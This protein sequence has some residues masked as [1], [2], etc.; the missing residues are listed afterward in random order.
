MIEYSLTRSRRK[1]IAIHITKDATVEVRAPLRAPKHAIDSFV[2]SKEDWIDRNVRK[3]KEKR[4]QK[5]AF[6]LDYGSSVLFLGNEYPITASTGKRARFDGARF[7]VPGGFARDEIKRAV[8][9]VYRSMAKK[10]IGEKV[11]RFSRLLCVTP[12]SLR[13]TGAKTR[14]GSCSGKNGI[15]FSWRLIMADEETVDYVVVH[16]LAHILQHNHSQWFWAT[17]SAVMPDYAQ[18]RAQLKTLHNRL[19]AEDWD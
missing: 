2:V 11:S 9:T 16:E 6:A 1:T 19:A 18:R 14:W 4:E 10:I 17:V 7:L 5:A 8:L 13:I 3:Q 12:L 15:S